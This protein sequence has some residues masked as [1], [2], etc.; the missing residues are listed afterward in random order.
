LVEVRSVVAAEAVIGCDF[1]AG[2][3]TDDMRVLVVKFDELVYTSSSQCGGNTRFFAAGSLEGVGSGRLLP[4]A[5]SAVVRFGVAFQR[6]R[7]EF[8]M[9]SSIK[10]GLNVFE[11]LCPGIKGLLGSVSGCRLWP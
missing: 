1:V 9:F 3:E 5:M 2:L 10:T 8:G 7:S 6:I 11:A 4:L